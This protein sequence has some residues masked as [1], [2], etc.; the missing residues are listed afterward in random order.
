MPASSLHK[1]I[2]SV[3]LSAFFLLMSQAAMAQNRTIDSLRNQLKKKLHD[4]DRVNTLNK[5]ALQ[6]EWMDPDTG[7]AVASKAYKLAE[8]AE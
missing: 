2:R 4:T 1:L 6:F 8:K 3:F 5:L 7:I